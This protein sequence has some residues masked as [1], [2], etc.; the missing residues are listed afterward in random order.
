MPVLLQVGGAKSERRK[1]IHTFN[2]VT[3]IIFT[4]GLNG[5]D[6]CLIEDQDDVGHNP[7][8]NLTAS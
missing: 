2:D 6:R 7:F 4:V 5:Y 3:V 8:P 1:W